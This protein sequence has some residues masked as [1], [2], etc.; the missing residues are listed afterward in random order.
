MIHTTILLSFLLCPLLFVPIHFGS[1]EI[2]SIPPTPCPPLCQDNHGKPLQLLVWRHL[3][4]QLL[5]WWLPDQWLFSLAV[6]VDGFRSGGGWFHGF[7]AAG[8]AA[9]GF[10]TAGLLAAG[11]Q[12]LGLAVAGLVVVRLKQHQVHRT[13]AAET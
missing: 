5:V 7:Y 8:C 11:F 13:V 2:S 9:S 12:A 3:V 1:S 4:S 6:P 10:A